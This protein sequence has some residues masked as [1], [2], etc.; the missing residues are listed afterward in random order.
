[1]DYYVIGVVENFYTNN[2]HD[3]VS[4][5]FFNIGT[6]EEFKFF[7]IKTSE[8]KLFDVDDQI[9]ASWFE[10]APNDP[11]N[12]E[13]Q[14]FTFDDFY[15]EN[16]GNVTLIGT[17]S[18]FAMVL[19][20][21]GLFGLLSFNLQRR[22]KEFGVRKVLGASRLSIL[23]QANKEYMWIMLV[24]FVIG[25]PLGTALISQLLKIIYPDSNSFSAA[26]IVLSV[27]IIMTT[28]AGTIIGQLL[29]A[30]KVNP[31]EVLR[32]E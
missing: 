17:I 2:F 7:V 27:V 6:N 21:L 25:A 10:F 15:R 28:V 12:R 20:C 14:R 8:D 11:Y 16:R 5:A 30:S 3:E 13:F 23:N 9:H 26:P 4:P 29:H 22:M 24:A 1:T 32:S 19:A 18:V 31:T